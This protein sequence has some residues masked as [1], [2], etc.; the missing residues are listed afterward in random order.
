MLRARLGRRR[1]HHGAERLGLGPIEG[2]CAGL[3]GMPRGG[4]ASAARRLA[5]GG[6]EDR[7]QG[8]LGVAG[9]HEAGGLALAR[10]HRPL[11]G[12]QHELF[13]P[14]LV[15]LVRV[16][17]GDPRHA[18]HVG[19][20]TRKRRGAASGLAAGFDEL[21]ALGTE[22]QV[23]LPPRG[24]AREARDRA[25]R[26]ARAARRGQGRRLLRS[27]PGDRLSLLRERAADAAEG[28]LDLIK[29]LAVICG[30]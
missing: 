29:G 16:R 28:F 30:P 18:L 9:H 21:E 14:G 26:R 13:V 27:A 7:A 2:L 20:R 5:R 15:G 17:L 1:R 22:D 25:P 8:F 23:E 3:R 19:P 6:L 24:R 4:G 11:Q 10:R 12:H